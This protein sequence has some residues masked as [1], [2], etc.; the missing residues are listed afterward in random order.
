MT[1][2]LTQLLRPKERQQLDEEVR[3]QR[4]ELAKA[5]VTGD[6]VRRELSSSV[7]QASD[8]ALKLMENDRGRR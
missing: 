5:L 3:R 7:M 2:S 6:R 1:W 4:G 8:G